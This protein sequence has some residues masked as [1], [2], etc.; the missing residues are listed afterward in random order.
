MIHA[1]APIADATRFEVVT[2]TIRLDASTTPAMQW[3]ASNS[4]AITVA[5]AGLAD[6]VARWA[7]EDMQ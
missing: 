3:L 4:D 5:C 1:P 7:Q 2:A 6:D